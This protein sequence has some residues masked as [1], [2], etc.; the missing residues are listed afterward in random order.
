MTRKAKSKN[1]RKKRDVFVK[2]CFILLSQFYDDKDV[3]IRYENK[4]RQDRENGKRFLKISL[5]A[6]NIIYC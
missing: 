2:K 3:R 6:I 5:Q 1:R 4:Q